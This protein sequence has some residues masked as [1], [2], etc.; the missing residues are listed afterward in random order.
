MHGYMEKMTGLQTEK[1]LKRETALV[2]TARGHG[3]LAHKAPQ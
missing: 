1:Q 2:Q 3:C